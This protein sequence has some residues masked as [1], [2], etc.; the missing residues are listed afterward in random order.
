MRAS[1]HIMPAKGSLMDTIRLK[2][3]LPFA[4]LPVI[5]AACFALWSVASRATYTEV[6][7]DTGVW[8]LRGLDFEHTSARIVGAV[9]FI[10]NALLTPE[11]FEARAEEIQ[12]GNPGAAAAYSTCRL[13][14]LLPEDATYMVAGQSIDYS[15]TFYLNGKLMAEIGQPGETKETSIPNTAVLMFMDEP[16]GGEIVIVQQTSNFV[17]RA[18]GGFDDWRVGYPSVVQ[19]IFRSDVTAIIMGC[20]LA[21]FLVHLT[22]FSILRSYRPNLYFSLFCLVWFLRTGVTD[23]KLF[24]TLLPAMSWYVK[25]RIEYL[26]LP[27]TGILIIQMLAALF[28][29]ILPR[30]FRRAVYGLGAV[31]IVLFL[32]TDTMFMSW[33][34]FGCYAYQGVAIAIVL[35]CFLG[36]LR[37][38]NMAQV[39]SLIGVALFLYA[40][41]RDMF[42]HNNILLPPV[43]NADLSQVSML[44]F[45]FFQMTAMF[46]GTVYA[47]EEA[48]ASEQRMAME[49]AALEEIGRLKTEFLGNISHELRTP[50]TVMSSHAQLVLE[51]LKGSTAPD[52]YIMQKML[53]LDG[54]AHRMAAVVDQLRDVTRMEENR[55]EWRFE[56]TDIASLI[57]D[58]LDSYY[59]ALVRAGNTLRTDLPKDL[60]AAYC[61][62]EHIRRVLL[63]IVMNAVRFTSHGS[64]TVAATVAGAFLAVSV[65]DTGS[66][67]AREN[68]P[69]L[70]DRYYSREARSDV[71]PTG[72]G[73]GLYIAKRTVEAHGGSIT[74]Q[75]E[76]GRGTTITFTLPLAAQEAHYGE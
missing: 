31:F 48:K 7:S 52:T 23:M 65:T 2:K 63:N 58:A 32:F 4:V 34:M 66:G 10:P 36:R 18:S 47:A 44:I 41:L 16:A 67:I 8:D 60:P 56:P 51:R 73:L 43:V 24:S 12:V 76:V 45:I 57:Q 20:F 62:R 37:R 75:S 69:Y 15:D 25:F 74:A 29:G 70:F 68:L 17:H 11:E 46:I 39:I 3:W 9:E 42:Y 13:R 26:S 71:A 72:T 1:V 61:D 55:T 22:L 38:P 50:L 19:A 28:P 21:L 59:P 27:V 35:V 30:W 49:K 40:G 5:L 54:E 6:L 33:A 64:V 14:I 53:L